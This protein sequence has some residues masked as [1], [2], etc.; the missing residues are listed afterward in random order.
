MP[1]NGAAK[2]AVVDDEDD[3]CGPLGRA[4][5][6]YLWATAVVAAYSFELGDDC[7]Q[8]P[9]ALVASGILS[10]SSGQRLRFFLGK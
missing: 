1:L 4:Q 3:L 7:F 9:T 8:V 10:L 5:S 6:L 2:A